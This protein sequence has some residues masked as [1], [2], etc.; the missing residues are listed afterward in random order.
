MQSKLMKSIMSREQDAFSSS[1]AV[2]QLLAFYMQNVKK[3]ST[4]LNFGVLNLNNIVQSPNSMVKF[5]VEKRKSCYVD[6]K[7]SEVSQIQ[8]SHDNFNSK[9]EGFLNN[10]QRLSSNKSALDSLLK[11]FKGQFED[12]HKL[13]HRARKW[14]EIN[15]LKI[16]D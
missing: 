1:F 9:I 14:V 15:R 16:V 6:Q 11:E 13:R 5:F 12:C 10:F 4:L 2:S 7:V 3:K 8:S